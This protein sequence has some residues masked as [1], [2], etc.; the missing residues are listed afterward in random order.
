MLHRNFFPVSPHQLQGVYAVKVCDMSE[1]NYGAYFEDRLSVFPYL[2][3][4]QVYEMGSCVCSTN[5]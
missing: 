4:M 1:P 2:L 3:E 5:H